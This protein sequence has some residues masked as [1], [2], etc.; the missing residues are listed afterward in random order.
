MLRFVLSL[1]TVVGL[2]ASNAFADKLKLR[3]GIGNDTDK[4]EYVKEADIVRKDKTLTLKFEDKNR[5]GLKYYQAKIYFDYRAEGDTDKDVVE[6]IMAPTA[7]Y[8]VIS[9]QKV[10]NLEGEEAFTL[11][12]VKSATNYVQLLC[13]I[14]DEEK[15]KIQ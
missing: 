5:F 10:L 12:L 3:C 15:V 4:L 11:Y 2:S 14:E 13:L 8:T 9:S 7:G 1:A 6:L